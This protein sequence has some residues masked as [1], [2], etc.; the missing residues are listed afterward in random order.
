LQISP[1]VTPAVKPKLRTVIAPNRLQNFV[2][3]QDS[4]PKWLGR[5]SKVGVVLAK[6][7]DKATKSI[8]WAGLVF[9]ID[10]TGT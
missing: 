9:R 4:M 8:F 6:D 1:R 2:I 3:D 10:A 5:V 7:F